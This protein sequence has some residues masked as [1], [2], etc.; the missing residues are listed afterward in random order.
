MIAD[1]VIENNYGCRWI[2]GTLEYLEACTALQPWR[3]QNKI[4]LWYLRHISHMYLLYT[5]ILGNNAKLVEKKTP[6]PITS[7]LFKRYLELNL[8]QLHGAHYLSALSHN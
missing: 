8:L 2:L 4:E 6:Y 5:I 7:S 3:K 1:Y